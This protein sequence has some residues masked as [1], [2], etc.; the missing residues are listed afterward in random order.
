MEESS[1]M[2][3]EQIFDASPYLRLFIDKEGRWFQNGAEIIHHRIYR[4]FNEMLEKSP[5]GEYRVRLGRETCRVEVED[6]PFVVLRVLESPV[7]DLS[8]ELND[9]TVEAFVP[10]HFWIGDAH[11]PY[12]TVKNGGFHARFSRPAYYQLAPFIVAD[13]AEKE[14]FLNINGQRL[15]VKTQ[16]SP[17]R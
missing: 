6:A 17:S 11:V 15:P 4:Q 8:I 14:F 3:S 13:E 2:A 12:T 7:H 9:G 16:T 1:G 5:D 10:E